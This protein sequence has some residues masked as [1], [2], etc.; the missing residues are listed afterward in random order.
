M[1]GINLFIPFVSIAITQHNINYNGPGFVKNIAQP[2]T[3]KM[4]IEAKKYKINFY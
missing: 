1:N 2:T 4:N 3:K